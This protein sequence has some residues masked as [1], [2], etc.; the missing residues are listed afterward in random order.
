M[1]VERQCP[2]NLLK[3]SMGIY[4]CHFFPSG[5]FRAP[6]L[7]EVFDFDGAVEFDPLFAP[8]LPPD[9]PPLL[10]SGKLLLSHAGYSEHEKK[11]LPAFDPFLIGILRICPLTHLSHFGPSD[12]GNAKLSQLFGASFF[13]LLHFR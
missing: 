3:T 10:S 12:S 13:Q 5:L 7:G 8:D 6:P 1:I 11:N 2:V 4:Q 9:E